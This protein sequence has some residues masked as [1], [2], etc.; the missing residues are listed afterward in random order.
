MK[1][2]L[3][4]LSLG[5]VI[6]YRQCYNFCGVDNKIP[7]VCHS[8]PLL[9]KMITKDQNEIEATTALLVAMLYRIHWPLRPHPI[10]FGKST[11][12]IKHRNTFLKEGLVFLI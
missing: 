1:K 4:I 7:E 12:R 2:I 9:T 10:G 5:F 11:R 6:T 8:L 3:P